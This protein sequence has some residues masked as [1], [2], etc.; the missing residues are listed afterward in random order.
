MTSKTMAGACGIFLLWAGPTISQT[1]L[2]PDAQ[3]EKEIRQT[4]LIHSPLPLDPSRSFEAAGAQKKVL[5]ARPLPICPDLSGWTSQGFGKITYGK[6]TNV[7]FSG[8]TSADG[9]YLRLAYPSFTGERAVG[10]PS[11]P[12]YATYGQAGVSLEPDEGTGL[13][14]KGV[15]WEDY[16]RIAFSIYPDC[17]GSR[18]VNLNLS[19]VNA[20]SA[21]TKPGFNRQSGEHLVNLTNKQWNRCFLDIDEYQRDRITRLGFSASLKGRDR[22]TGDSLVFYIGDIELQRIE[23]PE[24][25]SGWLPDAGTIAYSTSGYAANDR[26]T[27]I[28]RDPF[29]ENGGREGGD[30]SNGSASRPAF[31]LCEAETGRTVYRGFLRKETT[32][33]GSFGVADFSPFTQSGTYR[34][35]VGA[36]ETPPFRIGYRIWENSL[37]RVLNFVFCQRCGYPVPGIHGTCHTDL[38]S[39][40]NGKEISYAGGWHDAGD[41]S[42]QTLQTADVTYTL[43]EAYERLKDTNDLLAARLLEEAEWGLEFVVRNRYGDGYRGS[44]VGLLIWQDGVVNSLDD[45]RSVRVHNLAFDNFL[46][47]A[48]EAYAARVIDRD[49][50][51]QTYLRR[52]AEEDFAFAM[53]R[54]RKTGYGEF[55]HFYEHSYNT[56]ES[57]YMATIAWAASQLYRLTGK[58]EYART[59]AE[60]IRLTLDCQQTEPLSADCPL[61][62]FFY[63]DRSRRSI[64]HY[65]HQSRE[66]VYMQSL[67]LLCETQPDHPDY[68]RWREAIRLYG[69]YLKGIRTYTAPYGMIPSGVYHIDEY[70]DSTAFYR[71]HLFPP[72]DAPALY[73]EQLKQG[74]RLDDRHYLKRFPVWFSI[75]N[76]NSAVHLSTG[77]AAA[78]CGR[79]LKDEELLR[80]GAE[81]LYWTVGK[82][83]FNQS[84]IYGEGYRY[85]Q[86]DSFSSGEITGEMPVGIRSLGNT[87]QPYWPQTNAA[88]YKEVWVTTAGKWISLAIEYP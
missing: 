31:E 48:Y 18:V 7:P 24:N 41:L 51:L 82:N 39:V 9:G 79:F 21:G 28:V 15:N 17:D 62:G 23:R 45:I 14:G 70:R 5:A 22:T 88:C 68:P 78:L 4:G 75:F 52:V 12:D 36:V 69:D 11:D 32:S 66:Q 67:I 10:P 49:P 25:V 33:I 73:K 13:D 35:R 57:Q 37:W 40:H 83:P 63:R 85:P 58:K 34:L 26:K 30:A 16:N 77:K 59:A 53:E 72:A 65:I 84:L 6:Q 47:A 42:Q 76:G 55:Y 8:K 60:T 80:I 64:V 71:L 61:R 87:D 81:Q 1:R 38:S 74:V 27:A 86:M 19:L 50:A 44:S 46:Y 56:S 43:L 20:P 2:T 29:S 54:H 3:L